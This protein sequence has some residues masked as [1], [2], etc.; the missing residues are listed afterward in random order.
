MSARSGPG[1]FNNLSDGRDLQGRIFYAR[2]IPRIEQISRVDGPLHRWGNGSYAV[3]TVPLRLTDLLAGLAR[4]NI[5]SSGHRQQRRLRFS[6]PMTLT[7]VVGVGFGVSG[8]R[9]TRFLS[10]AGDFSCVG[11]SAA[12]SDCGGDDRGAAVRDSCVVSDQ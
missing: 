2:G 8:D 4:P 6:Q 7:L 1:D 10:P 12:R 9:F 11:V 5:D 3:A